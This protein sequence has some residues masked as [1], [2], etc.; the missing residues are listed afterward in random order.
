[1]NYF[2]EGANFNYYYFYYFEILCLVVIVDLTLV[3]G[4]SKLYFAELPSSDIAPM[5]N[6]EFVTFQSVHGTILHST[7]E[8]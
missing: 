1:M 2:D 5:L 7:I 3:C 6:K 4:H 8:S